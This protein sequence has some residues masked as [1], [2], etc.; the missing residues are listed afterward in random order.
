MT[1]KELK[2]QLKKLA[3]AFLLIMVLLI[4]LSVYT[5]GSTKAE[6]SIYQKSEKADIIRILG[7]NEDELK[8]YLSIVGNLAINSPESEEIKM[9][10][11]AT[12]YIDT[13]CSAY[14]TQTN[15]NGR[16]Y[17]DASIVEQVIKEINGKFIKTSTPLE[18]RYTY[19]KEENSYIQ[20]K[21]TDK[22]PYCLQIDN[23]TQNADTIEVTYQLA[24]MTDV[25]MAEYK[26]G[27]EVNLEIYT[28][29]ATLLKNTDYEYCKY[30]LSH[31]E[32]K[33]APEGA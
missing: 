10:D 24:N 15:E 4:V 20:N 32:N 8:Q 12:N 16:K 29:K 31:L 27:K 14:E 11:M 13:M 26:T 21:A 6:L 5:L 22:T 17:Y 18:D 2:K 33:K 23:I 9:L 7:L 25:Q 1:D 3:I 30:F 28:V 19:S